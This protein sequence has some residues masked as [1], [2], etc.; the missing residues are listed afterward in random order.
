M[1]HRQ[2]RER[3]LRLLASGPVNEVEIMRSLGLD[4]WSPL[5]KR[6]I[7]GTMRK[8]HG[9]GLVQEAGGSWRLRDGMGLCAACR[10]H[11]LVKRGN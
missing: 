5:S 9:E 4:I 6:S 1:V 11:G 3:I 10:G 8:M 2:Y 7:Q